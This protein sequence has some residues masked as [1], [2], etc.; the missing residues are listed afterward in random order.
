MTNTMADLTS[1][2]IFNLR[3][4]GGL[5]TGD[6]RVVRSGVLLR[7]DS[8]HRIPPE[9]AGVLA[10]LGV[11]LIV[12]L[13]SQGE[14]DDH[15]AGRLPIPT[16]HMPMFDDTRSRDMGTVTDLS[17]A[18]VGM[19]EASGE[20][21]GRVISR[22]AA[23]GGLP[24][25]VH[26]TAGKDRTGLVVGLLLSALGVTDEDVA[27]DY[28]RTSE[29]TEASLRW[30]ADHDPDSHALLTARP[31]W[32]LGAEAATMLDVLAHLREHHGSITAWLGSVGVTDDTL[33]TLADAVLEDG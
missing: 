6:G 14:L 25:L 16:E 9:E 33:S 28:A 18:Y 29:I 31:A 24:A 2:G 3:D 21:F 7:S 12:D 15:G 32:V 13:R 1:Y 26:C 27:A 17:G 8:P 11:G 22:L 20:R 10:D 30:L 19:L 4:V 5:R 23:P